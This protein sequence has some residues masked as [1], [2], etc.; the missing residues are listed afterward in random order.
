MTTAIS[1][2]PTV[3]GSG[4]EAL[5]RATLIH[6]TLSGNTAERIVLT[7]G[8][9]SRVRDTDGREYL[10]ASAVLGV[11]QVGHGRAELARVAA[12]QMARLEY[13]DRKSVV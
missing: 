2:L 6:P 3:P 7:S 1:A 9:G 4:L 12:E 11:T 10:D 8:S 13:L 5:D